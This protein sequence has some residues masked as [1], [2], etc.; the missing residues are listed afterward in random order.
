LTEYRLFDPENPP[1]WLDSAWWT[2]T[3]NC[4]H[5]DNWVHVARLT[6]SAETALLAAKE[7]GGAQITDLGAGDGGLLSLLPEPYRSVSYGYEIITDSVRYANEVRKV[8]VRPAHVT[9]DVATLNIAPVAVCT[10]MLEHLADPDAFVTALREHAG[11][12][13][14]IASS[15]HSETDQHHEWN[16]AWAWDHDGYRD[17]F[18]RNGWAV[19]SHQDAEW[20]QVLWATKI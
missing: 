3:G 11:A 4:N 17:L 13:H 20:S 6:C 14:L 19:R 18:E 7:L 12:K 8:D 5:L 2:E 16:H 1:E 15:P 9:R 10:E